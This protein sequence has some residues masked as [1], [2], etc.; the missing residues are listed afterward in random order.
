MCNCFVSVCVASGEKMADPWQECMDYAVTLAGQAG[1]VW[2]ESSA[3]MWWMWAVCGCLLKQNMYFY[4]SGFAFNLLNGWILP[5]YV[6]KH[7]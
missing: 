3:M 2:T 1:E 7:L 5:F 6:I 4:W